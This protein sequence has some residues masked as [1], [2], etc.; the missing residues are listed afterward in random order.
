LKELLSYEIN[1]RRDVY[2]LLK[3]VENL[4]EALRDQKGH[5]DESEC[6]DLTY[7]LIEE[8]LNIFLV[9]DNIPDRRFKHLHLAEELAKGMDATAIT[10]FLKAKRLV[11]LGE[12]QK[13]E[14]LLTNDRIGQLKL[15]EESR[16]NLSE[17]ISLLSNAKD[18]KEKYFLAS[19]HR[20]IGVTYEL[21]GDNNKSN[22]ERKICYDR[23]RQHSEKARSIL[24]SLKEDSV[25]FYA[26]MN[27]AS[28]LTRIA[29]REMNFDLKK[30]LLDRGYNLLENILKPLEKLEDH[31]GLGWTHIHICDNLRAQAKEAT[32][33][34]DQLNLLSKVEMHANCALDELRQTLDTL[35]TGLAYYHLGLS[36]YEIYVI[37]DLK[38]NVSLNEASDSLKQ[39]VERIGDG[40]FFRATAEAYLV[41]SKCYEER[42]RLTGNE[43]L[44]SYAIEWRTKA[45][46]SAAIGLDAKEVLD[47]LLN[48]LDEEVTRLL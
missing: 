32:E 19:A 12:L 3:A 22:N 46:L 4:Q 15:F 23:W 38:S 41:L 9:G 44:I 35:A 13:E 5:L 18:T 11:I 25:Y 40:G 42:A 28:S 47:N 43:E 33:A 2:R 36:A 24:K 14:A 34:T 37:N 16:Q 30:Q 39:A 8:L 26:T 21:E 1:G 10:D 31:R 27:L 29:C 20:H 17:A 6:F 48:Y 45:I 7:R